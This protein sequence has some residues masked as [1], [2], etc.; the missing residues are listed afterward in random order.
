MEELNE[1]EKL[2]EVIKLESGKMCPD[3][4]TGIIDFENGTRIFYKNGKKHRKNGPAI[5]RKSG[6]KEWWSNGKKHRINA[7]A[8]EY[9][10]G[11]KEWWNNGKLHRKNG[12]ALELADGMKAW[13]LE[14]KAYGVPELNQLI[15]DCV[16]IGQGKGKHGFIYL[17]FITINGIE[18]FPIMP[19]MEEY[20]DMNVLIQILLNN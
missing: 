13:F 2:L 8:V 1:E 5:E 12:A 7:P 18:E 3:G 11:D 14:G 15:R 6:H 4:F 17:K 9:T 20:E 10:N 19:E 16:F